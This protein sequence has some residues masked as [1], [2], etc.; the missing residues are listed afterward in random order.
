[1]ECNVSPICFKTVNLPA[2]P[3]KNQ[4]KFGDVAQGNLWDLCPKIF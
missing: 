1:M 3:P 4:S 2:D